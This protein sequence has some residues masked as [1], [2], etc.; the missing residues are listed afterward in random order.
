MTARIFVPDYQRRLVIEMAKAGHPP[1]IIARDPA[2]AVGIDA[3]YAILARARAEGQP[4][5]KFPAFNGPRP[6]DRPGLVVRVALWRGEQVRAVEAAARAR[7]LTRSQ[8]VNR[9]VEQALEHNL[10][11][12]VLDDG[13]GDGAG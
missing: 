10:I 5:P 13:V 3:I 1:R 12:A 11:G 6:D 4:V 2:V 8:L 9:L 7:N